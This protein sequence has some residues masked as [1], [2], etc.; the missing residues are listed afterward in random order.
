MIWIQA[1]LQVAICGVL[2][3][4]PVTIASKLLPSYSK[5]PD[6]QNPPSVYEWQTL[7]VICIGLWALSRAVPDLVYWV[8]YMGMAFE[9]DAPL[10]ELAPD[11]K[12][13]FIATVVEIIVGAWLVLGAKGVAAL[14]FKIRTAGVA[15]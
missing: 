15:K 3:F 9:S 11:Q 14:L 2:W 1:A 12:A 7:G 10:G 4:F 8:A 13:G 5:P 6:P